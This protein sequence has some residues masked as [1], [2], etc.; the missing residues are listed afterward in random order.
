MTKEDRMSTRTVPE[1]V[2]QEGERFLSNIIEEVQ[3]EKIKVEQK[4]KTILARKAELIPAQDELNELYADERNL[5]HSLGKINLQLEILQLE[6]KKG[7]G[8]KLFKK[9]MSRLERAGQPSTCTG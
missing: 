1:I 2:E 5:T 6:I 9:T 3:Q 7:G 4:L 8:K